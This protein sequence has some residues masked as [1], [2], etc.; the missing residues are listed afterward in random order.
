MRGRTL[1][2]GLIA[3][4][5]AACTPSGEEAAGPAAPEPDAAETAAVEP[6]PEPPE[7][8]LRTALTVATPPTD[9][10]LV[11]RITGDIDP[12]NNPTFTEIPVGLASREGMFGRAEAVVALSRMHEAAAA[13]G[14]ELVVLSAFRSFGD[15]KR[16]WNNK[17]TG[18]TL[19]EGGALPD[20]VP[21]PDQRARKILE[22]SSMP[23]TSRHHWGTDFDLNNLDNAWFDTPVGVKTYD[24]LV[25]NAAD[26]GFCQV[27]TQK[28]SDRP[29]GYEM[30]KWH[31]SYMPLAYQFLDAYP[32]LMGY[33]H[34]SGFDGAETAPSINV[35]ADYV[36]GIAPTCKTNWPK[37]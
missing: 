5:L 19:V 35:I 31:W 23:A 36:E 22:Y 10:E 12:R 3:A 28:G 9:A 26:F 7:E 37:D 29:A 21:D 27:Y 18:V 33:A 1:G 20:A 17:W 16:I 32:G 14:V 34:I 11:A 6:P 4:C 13:D 2:L 24:W 15:Q 8:V 25:Q 30:E